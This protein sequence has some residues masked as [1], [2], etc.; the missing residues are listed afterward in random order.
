M[1]A[2]L[3]QTTTGSPPLREA[4]AQLE[5]PRNGSMSEGGGGHCEEA[6]AWVSKEE[7]MMG[8][9]VASLSPSQ[10]WCLW[11][12]SS[13]SGSHKKSGGEIRGVAELSSNEELGGPCIHSTK[14]LR[15]K[16]MEVG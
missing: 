13:F 4:E 8:N 14:K 7:Q 16:G 2:I 3:I 6:G 12:P 10:V 15:P 1:R 11:G 5:V 9:G